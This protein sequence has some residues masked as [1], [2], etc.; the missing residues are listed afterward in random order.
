MGKLRLST[1]AILG[2]VI[3]SWHDARHGLEDLAEHSD[4]IRVLGGLKTMVKSGR[5]TTF[6]LQKLRSPEP[7]FDRWY[8]PIQVAMAAD[9]LMRYFKKLRNTIEKEGLPPGGT[10][11]LEVFPANADV[12][13]CDVA[14]GE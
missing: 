7:E 2:R 13:I 4:P 1:S 12:F 10:A 3:A 6:V 11:V 14:F 5:E 8:E 9:P